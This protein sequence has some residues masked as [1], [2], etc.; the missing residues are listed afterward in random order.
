MP[1]NFPFVFFQFFTAFLSGH[2]NHKIINDC[3]FNG[4]CMLRH[5]FYRGQTGGHSGS[6][7]FTS[8]TGKR[9]ED[10]SMSK[11][12]FQSVGSLKIERFTL[13]LTQFDLGKLAG[14]SRWRICMAETGRIQLTKDENARISKL[15]SKLKKRQPRKL[16]TGMRFQA[17]TTA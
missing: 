3:V 15:F 14:V 7:H 1:G 13:G 8:L 2:T 11:R 16:E 6:I 9:V 12:N 4:V 5:Y 10:Y 17:E